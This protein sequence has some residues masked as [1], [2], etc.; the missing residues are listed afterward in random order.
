LLPEEFGLIGYCLVVIQYV[1]ILNSAGIATALIARRE[2]VQEAAN[3]AFM[4]NIIFGLLTFAIT[5]VIATPVSVFLMS[6]EIV[7][8]IQDAGLE[9]AAHRPGGCSRYD[10]QARDEVSDCAH[11]GYQP[12]LYEGRS[13]DWTCNSWI[14]RL[15]SCLG[16]G[17][18]RID[19]HA[20]FRG[21]WPG[22]GQ[23]GVLTPAATRSI[24]FFGF[25]IILLE[26]AGA[27]RNNVDYLL[28][29]TNARRSLAGLLH[30][31]LS[32]P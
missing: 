7:P 9:P 20:F 27:F 29:G 14:W 1:D 21:S 30:H 11:F 25:H 22:G 26:T 3:A 2:N 8:S 15:E 5:W 28:V 32:H 18:R 12:Q 13:I 17:D 19:G 23:P 10:A 6:P 24:V 16:T 4:A 31:V